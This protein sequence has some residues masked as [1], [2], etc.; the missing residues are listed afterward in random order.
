MEN[1]EVYL[2]M[3]LAFAGII[4]SAVFGTYAL[5]QNK[6]QREFSKEQRRFLEDIKSSISTKF[7]GKFPD[8]IN[9]INELLSRAED[10]VYIVSDL[11]AY[12]MYSNPNNSLKYRSLLGELSNKKNFGVSIKLITYSI[13]TYKNRFEEQFHI[14][15][16]KS[17]A[18]KMKVI[19]KKAEQF[20][21]FNSF[22]MRQNL[23]KDEIKTY[24]DLFNFLINQNFKMINKLLSTH[25][26]KYYEV[27]WEK[28][29][30]KLPLSMWIIDKKYAVF[31]F[32]DYFGEISG[33][34]SFETGDKNVIELLL[35]NFNRFIERASHTEQEN[36]LEKY[37]LS[38]MIED[39]T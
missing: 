8:N 36:F 30:P 13:A 32:L 39:A 26:F 16:L 15:D 5:I 12:G 7:I 24:D 33:E 35:N 38:N 1:F 21:E 23:L 10:S 4:V 2:S 17:G 11:A 29:K 18:D 3:V 6:K 14:T 31:S 19:K 37:R 27:D 20:S 25:Q 22:Y 28:G 34:V 9:G